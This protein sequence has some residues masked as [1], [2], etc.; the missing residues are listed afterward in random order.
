MALNNKFKK[1]EITSSI[2]SDH[3]GMKLEINYKKKAGKIINMQRLNN[4]LLNNYFINEKLKGRIKKYLKTN[5][6][7]NDISKPIRCSKKSSIKRGFYNNTDLVQETRKISN[8]QS[9]LIPKGTRKRKT[10]KSQHKQKEGNSKNQ[11]RNK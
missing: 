2:F 6:N 10:N 7:K 11:S 5:E 4:M 1:T 3:S 9:N 8:K